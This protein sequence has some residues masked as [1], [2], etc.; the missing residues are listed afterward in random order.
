MRNNY[1]KFLLTV[2]YIYLD[3]W[4]KKMKAYIFLMMF[5]IGCHGTQHDC[6]LALSTHYNL[7]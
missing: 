4:N 5:V 3:E 7:V 1:D 2:K 6:D